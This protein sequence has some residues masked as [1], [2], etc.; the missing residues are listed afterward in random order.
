MHNDDYMNN[1][2]LIYRLLILGLGNYLMGDDGAGIHLIKELRKEKIPVGVKL[3]E[4]GTAPINYLEEIS[5]SKKLIAVDIIKGGEKSGTVYKLNLKDLKE[6]AVN[7]AHGFSLFDVINI[8]QSITGLPKE[9]DIYGIEPQKVNLNTILSKPVENSV[10]KIKKIIY[11]I[12]W[13]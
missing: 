8:A 3:I 6:T 4:A 5:K 13:Y 2:N 7:D 11:N 10:K 12:I 1:N 9:V